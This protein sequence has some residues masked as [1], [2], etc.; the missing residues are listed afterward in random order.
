MGENKGP[1]WESQW[2]GNDIPYGEPYRGSESAYRR[3]YE[4]APIPS[5]KESKQIHKKQKQAVKNQKIAKRRAIR[6]KVNSKLILVIIVIL[7]AAVFIYKLVNGIELIGPD[8][9][10]L[11]DFR[12]L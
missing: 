12:R 8:V 7:V 6:S 5:P 1:D 2:Q 10:N 11:P 3:Q 4:K 9:D